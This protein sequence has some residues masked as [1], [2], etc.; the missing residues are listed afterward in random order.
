M[1]LSI[2][3]NGAEKR[4][5]LAL[6]CEELDILNVNNKTSQKIV[7]A[8]QKQ[9]NR[10]PDIFCALIGELYYLYLSC[11]SALI[12]GTC[13]SDFASD[14]IRDLVNA[15]LYRAKCLLPKYQM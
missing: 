2:F 6:L 14:I 3:R 5:T 11:S 4:E 12:S 1:K 15:A 13:C 8:S 10:R 9:R 7:F